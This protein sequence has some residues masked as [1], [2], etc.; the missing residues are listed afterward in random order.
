MLGADDGLTAWFIAAG[1]WLLVK[2]PLRLQ[3][4]SYQFGHCD[5]KI[6]HVCSLRHVIGFV[7]VGRLGAEK[8]Q[9]E[10]QIGPAGMPLNDKSSKSG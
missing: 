2:R 4:K 9:S 5:Q 10:R 8:V 1:G 3:K 6:V 7:K